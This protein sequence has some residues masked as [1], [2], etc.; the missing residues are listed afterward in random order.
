MKYVHSS[1]RL[2]PDLITRLRLL[3]I[4]NRRSVNQQV[5]LILEEALGISAEGSVRQSM[6]LQ[7]PQI[8]SAR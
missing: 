5:T 1:I 6:V 4:E 2:P 7:N 8:T 3:A